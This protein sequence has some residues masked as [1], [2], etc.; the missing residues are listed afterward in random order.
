M[1][2]V[3]QHLNKIQEHYTENRMNAGNLAICFGFVFLPSD[4]L[5]FLTIFQTNPDGRKLWRQ[6]CRCRLASPRHRDDPEQHLPDFRRRLN[7]SRVAISDNVLHAL[8]LA[9]GK[10]TRHGSPIL[11]R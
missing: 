1:L 6:H 11:I 4:P 10:A 2:T 9:A 7:A 8:D 5:A 3:L